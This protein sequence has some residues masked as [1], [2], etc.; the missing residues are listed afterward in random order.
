MKERGGF[1]SIFKIL[2]GGTPTISFDKLKGVFCGEFGL[3]E[4]ETL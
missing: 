4:E 1:E 2:F 3:L